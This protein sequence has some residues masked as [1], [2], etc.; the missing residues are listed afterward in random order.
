MKILYVLIFWLISLNT[1]FSQE[2]K[3]V[4]YGSGGGITGRVLVQKFSNDKIEFGSG[5][6]G[7]VYNKSVDYPKRF[8]KKISKSAQ[9]F[10]NENK[11]INEVSNLY[12]LLQIEYTD[13]TLKTYKWNSTTTLSDNHKK[14]I[15]RILKVNKKFTK[16]EK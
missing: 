13:G 2:I 10:A 5:L 6:T 12:Q 3:S 7:F 11:E 14:L 9:K 16:D 4:L 1:T 8:F 15:S